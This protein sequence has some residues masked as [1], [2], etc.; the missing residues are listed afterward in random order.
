MKHRKFEL[1]DLTFASLIAALYVLLTFFAS[2][3][4]TDAPLESL[5]T[6]VVP[7]VPALFLTFKVPAVIVPLRG[8]PLVTTSLLVVEEEDEDG[9]LVGFGVGVLV[10]VADGAAVGTTPLVMMCAA[11]T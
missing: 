3:N 1:K 7:L 4:S 10:G 2:N 8:K 9:L 11:L 6:I 5:P